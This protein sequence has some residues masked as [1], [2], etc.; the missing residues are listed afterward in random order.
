MCARSVRFVLKYERNKALRFAPLQSGLGR[1]AAAHAG[2]DP[3][4]L[5]SMLFVDE[6]GRPSI[7]S[8]AVLLV[9]RNLRLPWR[10]LRAGR[11][12]PRFVRDRVYDFVAH[13]RHRWFKA[14]DV[15]E[16]ISADDAKR[17]IHT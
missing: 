3:T 1:A 17:V 11:I 16:L 2:L 15:C 8:T 13:R 5:S 9:A 6:S 12:V 10:L 7:K 14:A 4:D